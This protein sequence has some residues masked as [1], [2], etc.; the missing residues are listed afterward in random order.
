L[1][2]LANVD[3]AKRRAAP[4]GSAATSPTESW[5]AFAASHTQ[6]ATEGVT[7]ALSRTT[8]VVASVLALHIAF[9]WALQSG[10]LM[11]AAEI[12]VPAEML[13]QFVAPVA[14]PVPP[15]PVPKPPV[16]TPPK[17]VTPQKQPTPKAASTPQPQPLAINDTTPSANA[18]TGV[19]SQ[20]AP[21]AAT[22]A[23]APA[24]PTNESATAAPAKIEQPTVD[25]RY[26][27]QDQTVYPAMSR[28]LGEQGTSVLR[29][30]IGTDGKAISAQLVK[31]SG[32]ERLDKA[33]YETVMRRRYVPGTRDGVPVALSYNAPIAWVLK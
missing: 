18:P 4:L 11:R 24:A 33:A 26:S 14:A 21:T 9:I 28:R 2:P 3:P 16:P 23:A 20:A 25:A 8:V 15:Q 30:L 7:P 31:S 5:P 13:A 27:D 32:F 19:L 29:V 1:T 12:I 17:P 6:S 10:L 22:A